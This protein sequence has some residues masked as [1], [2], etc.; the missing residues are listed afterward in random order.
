MK[1]INDAINYAFKL[2]NRLNTHVLSSQSD[3][4]LFI[5]LFLFNKMF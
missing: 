2:K 5:Y 4:N 3:A 1:K